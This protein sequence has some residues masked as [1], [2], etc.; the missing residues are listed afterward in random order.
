M[1][2][3]C[4]QNGV[5]FAESCAVSGF[6]SNGRETTDA[7]GGKIM[8]QRLKTSNRDESGWNRLAEEG[9]ER[10]DEC[11]KSS[12]TGKQASTEE[13]HP[14]W[15]IQPIHFEGQRLRDVGHL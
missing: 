9:G 6:S 10:L 8:M 5:H 15:V 3:R 4:P 11:N 1:R 12:G 2:L 14:G 7:I 13:D